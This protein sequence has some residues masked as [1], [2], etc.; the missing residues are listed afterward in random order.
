MH[1][2]SSEDKGSGPETDADYHSVKQ[3]SNM[4]VDPRK[5]QKRKEKKSTKNLPSTEEDTLTEA[6]HES[7][8]HEGTVEK[9]ARTT[10]IASLKDALPSMSAPEAGEISVEFQTSLGQVQ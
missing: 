6:S 5:G 1:L 10:T 8:D 9:R 2:T 4:E 7:Q 3:D